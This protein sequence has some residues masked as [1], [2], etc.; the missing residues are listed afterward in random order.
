MPKQWKV[1]H[2]QAV[3]LGAEEEKQAVGHQRRGEPR[4]TA[5]VAL[6]LAH[7]VWPLGPELRDD[8]HGQRASD[9]TIG[10]GHEAVGGKGDRGR[11]DQTRH[12]PSHQRDAFGTEVVV[13]LAAAQI[14]MD[15][16]ED[17]GR[18]S[19][20]HKPAR[21]LRRFEQARDRAGQEHQGGGDQQAPTDIDQMDQ[22]LDRGGVAV[23]VLDQEPIAA[24]VG[25]RIEEGAGDDQ[26]GGQS[27]LLGAEQP[28]QD[29]VAKQGADLGA[30]A[31][32][33]KEISAPCAA[34]AG[35]WDPA[36]RRL[37]TVAPALVNEKVRLALAGDSPPSH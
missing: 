28:R 16:T 11:R 9:Q 27:E 34:G 14:E 23:L 6:A 32:A 5:G 37:A 15:E 35:E 7:P 13:A 1:D 20:D 18:E 22:A 4:Q 21:H 33:A 25:H 2:H 29:R 12:F 3:G 31:V 26:G 10:H 24:A 30:T 36:D 8:H 17:Q 19:Q